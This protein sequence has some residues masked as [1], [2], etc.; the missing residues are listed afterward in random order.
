MDKL[1]IDKCLNSD[2]VAV[3]PDFRRG[4]DRM[5][6]AMQDYPGRILGMCC[7]N[8]HYPDEIVPELEKR[9]AQGFTGVKIHP[10]SNSYFANGDNYHIL[11]EY[12]NK[13]NGI[14]ISHTYK[15]ED[16]SNQVCYPSLFIEIAKKYKHMNII[17]GHSGGAPWGYEESIKMARKFD[18]V[19]LEF[20]STEEFSS[21]WLEKIVDKAGDDKTFFGTDM[22]FHDP[23]GALGEVLYARI[24]DKSKEKI[25]GLNVDRLIKE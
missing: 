24:P 10:H 18:N 22:P 20:C 4:N 25:L 17:L 1:G 23:R 12:L 7:V 13:H 11:Y 14:V 9:F 2:I 6:R 16:I 19:Y 21:Y 3:G 15:N 5:Y 8:P